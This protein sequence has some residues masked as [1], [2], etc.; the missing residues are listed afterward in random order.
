MR[1]RGF[2]LVELLVVIGII[3]LL[4][5]ILLPALK[6]AR[7]QALRVACASN[8]RQA[9]QCMTMYAQQFKDAA[10]LGY[11][12]ERQFTYVIHWNNGGS[13]PPK[14]SQMGMLVL[15]HLLPVPKTYYCP[16]EDDPLYMFNTP[17]NQWVFD[18]TPPH[19]YLTQAGSGRHTRMGY[20]ARPIADWPT[21]TFPVSDPRAF[22]PLL[23][24]KD[25]ANPIRAYPKWN[26]LKSK[27]VLADMIVSPQNVIRRHRTGVNVLYG[28]ASVRYIALKSFINT[29][30]WRFIGY[31]DVQP[32]WNDEMLHWD[33]DGG[34]W[35]ELDKQ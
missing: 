1:K 27:A 29:G 8:M 12:D 10:P 4:I 15:A 16:A 26:K 13:T 28:D 9:G 5:A 14:P 34:V 30:A 22:T 31:G 6:K 24:P 19:P 21:N 23:E 25:P 32:N 33:P 20:N 7:D 2:T 3:A 35:F 11:M 18:Q 17:E